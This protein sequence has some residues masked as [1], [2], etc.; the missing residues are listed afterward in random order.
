[1]RRSGGVPAALDEALTASDVDIR[2]RAAEAVAAVGATDRLVP[3]LDD[4]DRAVR[5]VSALAVGESGDA[6]A[7]C[8][9]DHGRRG[10]SGRRGGRRPRRVGAAATA[11]RA[12]LYRAGRAAGHARRA[13]GAGTGAGSGG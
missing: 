5:A 7:A 8:V 3:A 6:R 4:P 2:R 10:G 11:C 12:D 9:A 13:P 1:L